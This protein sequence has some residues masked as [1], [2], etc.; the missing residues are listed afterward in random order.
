MTTTAGLAPQHA[1]RKN[2]ITPRQLGNR[3]PRSLARGE[4]VARA[5]A[6]RSPP[7]GHLGVYFGAERGEPWDIFRESIG[8]FSW[9]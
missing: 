5:K 2:R 3:F 4:R 8:T 6:R 1:L 7:W 9:A